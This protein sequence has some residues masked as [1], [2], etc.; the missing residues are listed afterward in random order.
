[1]AG[2]AWRRETPLRGA[3]DPRWAVGGKAIGRSFDGGPACRVCPRPPRAGTPYLR[4]PGLF[5]RLTR[6]LLTAPALIVHGGAGPVP[7]AERPKRQSAVERALEL[8]WACIGDGALAAA[9]AAVRHMEDEP[10]LNAGIGA[11]LNA[12]GEVELDAGVMEGP[13]LRAAGLAPLQ[14]LHHPLNLPR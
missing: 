3:R 12:D 6:K 13:S 7:V 1:M 5:A 9:V 8:G 14:H 11:C 4:P 10:L 2:G